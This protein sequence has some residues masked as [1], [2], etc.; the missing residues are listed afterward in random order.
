MPKHK[1]I[2]LKI[3]IFLIRHLV[4]LLIDKI[5]EEKQDTS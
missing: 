1:E 2:I 3:S 4:R 5:K